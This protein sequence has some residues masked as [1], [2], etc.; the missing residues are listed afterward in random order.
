MAVEVHNK[1]KVESAWVIK[2][3]IFLHPMDALY[4]VLRVQHKKKCLGHWVV[5]KTT[6][7][8]V[9]L[10]ACTY[11]WSQISVLYFLSAT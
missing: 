9:D 1:F 10:F 3:S 2:S 11:A 8:R 7:A 6:I 5:M 4:A